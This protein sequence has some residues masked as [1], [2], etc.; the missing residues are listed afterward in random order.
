MSPD[1]LLEMFLS[2]ARKARDE[3]PRIGIANSHE[4]ATVGR[5]AVWLGRETKIVELEQQGIFVDTE[6]GQMNNAEMK[7][8]NGRDARIDMLV[9][10][11][12][13]QTTNLLA[14]EVKMSNSKPSCIEANDRAKLEKLT[15][16]FGYHLGLWISLPRSGVAR[17]KGRYAI[18]KAGKSGLP[19]DL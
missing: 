7:H 4:W 8:L 9:H 11:R 17:N 2:A 13:L 14:C 12:G 6:Y 19:R 1:Q 16:D 3:E 5:I 15:L 10:R 18:V